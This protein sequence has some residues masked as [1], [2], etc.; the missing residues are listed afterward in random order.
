[1]EVGE[2]GVT[3]V[4]VTSGWVQFETTSGQQLV[5]EGAVTMARP[6]KGVGT[7]YFDGA[8]AAFKHAVEAFDSDSLTATTRRALLSTILGEARTADVY[9]LLAL[10]RHLTPA[11]RGELYDRAA[12]LRRPPASVTRDGIIAGN[13]EM[14]DAWRHRL[15]LPEVKRWWIHWADALDF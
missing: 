6:G 10:L 13:G 14:L 4:R 1:M 5:P 3:T 11:E 7:P 9:T 8:T 15:G 12:A 2:D